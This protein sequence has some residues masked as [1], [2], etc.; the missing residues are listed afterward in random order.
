MAKD[1]TMNGRAST[2]HEPELAAPTR[3]LLYG[4]LP[5]LDATEAIIRRVRA[6][7][8]LGLISD[9][10]RLPRES[11]LAEQL[12]VTNFTLRE[13]LGEL[14]QQG[15]IETRAGKYGGSF[16]KAPMEGAELAHDELL[17]LSSGELRDLGDWRRMLTG[18]AAALA[19]HR[20]S[21]SNHHRLQQYATQVGAASSNLEA[22][23]AHGRFH[24][25]LASATQS[26]RMTRAEF[27]VHE[28]IDWLFGMSLQNETQRQHSSLEL[29]AITQ[30]VRARQPSK[31]RA[32]AEKYSTHLV[33]ELAQLRLETIAERRGSSNAGMRDAARTSLPKELGTLL[34]ALVDELDALAADTAP[35]L[36]SSLRVGQLGA[37]VSVAVLKRIDAFPA[38]IDGIGLLSEVEVVP[39][40]PYWL[41][42]WHNTESGPV[43]EIGHVTDPTRE[44]FY[45]YASREYM[46]HPREHR[47]PWASGPYID[48]GGVD[49]YTITV[50]VP[51]L[52]KDRFLGVA[53]GDIRVADLERHVAPWLATANGTCTLINAE[54]RVIFSNSLEHGVGDL[55]NTK[56]DYVAT[57]FTELGWTLL[58]QINES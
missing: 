46:V 26:A 23:R 55:I 45:D 15:L 40:H 39:E 53:A 16:V 43:E 29:L 52:H 57:D 41:N 35:L 49:D 3:R 51:I 37:Q 21:E 14:R 22:R 50:S 20:A 13:A 1:R 9:G 2:P 11:D 30:A 56:G 10:D 47:E 19:A 36:G 18:N 7:I 17:R 8:G 54:S 48:Y 27:T 33:N 34:S 4:P 24:V 58:Q 12:G 32:R 6:A 25:E 5:A 42:W 44:D 38:F 31:A 28:E